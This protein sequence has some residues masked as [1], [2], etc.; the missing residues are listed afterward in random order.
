M[1]AVIVVSKSSDEFLCDPPHLVNLHGVRVN[2]YLPAKDKQQV[3]TDLDFGGKYEVGILG[4]VKK[5]K[6]VHLFVK[7]CRQLSDKYPV[8]MC[9]G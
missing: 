3:W 1:E 8:T 5:Q 7:G 6:G 4:H 2:D 9:C